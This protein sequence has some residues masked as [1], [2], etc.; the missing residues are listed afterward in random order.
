[1]GWIDDALEDV[2]EDVIELLVKTLISGLTLTFSAPVI[3]A[4]TVFN[5]SVGHVD[6]LLMPP[7]DIGFKR[8]SAWNWRGSQ[9]SVTYNRPQ[10][11]TAGVSTVQKKSPR[12]TTGRGLI[13]P[14]SERPA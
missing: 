11:T 5:N 7:I 6:P 2:A 13:N 3:A 9:I 8:P 1:M 14:G 4:A 10:P 12:A